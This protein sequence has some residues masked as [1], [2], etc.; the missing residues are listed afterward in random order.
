[1]RANILYP[2]SREIGYGRMA[3]D[4]VA[5][6]KRQGVEVFDDLPNPQNSGTAKFIPHVNGKS[7]IC[8]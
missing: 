4:L 7:A 6:L 3:V 5:A 2:H 1:M 8:A